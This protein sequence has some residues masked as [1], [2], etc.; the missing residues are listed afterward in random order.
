MHS[1]N[2]IHSIFKMQCIT[3]IQI[4]LYNEKDI[5]V[6]RKLQKSPNWKH[7]SHILIATSVTEFDFEIDSSCAAITQTLALGRTNFKVAHHV[8]FWMKCGFSIRKWRNF[9]FFT[10]AYIQVTAILLLPVKW[11][12]LNF[13]SWNWYSIEMSTVSTPIISTL[14]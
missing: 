13:I 1:I 12:T 2:T 3:D 10:M 7:L 14:R 4:Q 6:Y 5:H 11:R 8:I 9:V